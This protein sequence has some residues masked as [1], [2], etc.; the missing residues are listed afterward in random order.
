M[1]ENID[2]GRHT[3]YENKQYHVLVSASLDWLIHH[4]CKDGDGDFL[5]INGRV[6]SC[7]SVQENN[8]I[9]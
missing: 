3:T 1:V 8:G 5:P 2:E 6:V 4:R 9:G 7:Q